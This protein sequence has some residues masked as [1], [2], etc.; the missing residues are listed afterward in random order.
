[1]LD[2]IT[3]LNHHQPTRKNTITVV[4]LC[5]GSHTVLLL[6]RSP[7]AFSY[8]DPYEF[9]WEL[10]GGQVE[11]GEE[12]AVAALREIEEETGLILPGL[13]WVGISPFWSKGEPASNWIFRAE[14]EREEPVRLS[15][16][17]LNSN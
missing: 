8:H 9:F 2:L 3:D 4:L 12:P 10:V 14:M 5:P 16:E 17:H 6:R 11:E 1:M 15:Q 7:S 13:Y